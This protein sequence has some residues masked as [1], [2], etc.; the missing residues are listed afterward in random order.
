M[1]YPRAP[2]KKKIGIG[3]MI[4]RRNPLKKESKSR[5]NTKRQDRKATGAQKWNLK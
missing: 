5:R 1:Y 4:E 2:S 3:N